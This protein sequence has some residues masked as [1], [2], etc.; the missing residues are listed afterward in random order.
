MANLT[1][2]YRLYV[3]DDGSIVLKM[4][5]INTN[6]DLSKCS[7]SIR[8]IILIM[9]YIIKDESK[10]GIRRK[11]SDGINSVARQEGINSSSVHAKITRKLGLS[12]SDFKNLVEEYFDSNFN[13]LDTILKNACVARTKA[14]DNYAIDQL[15]RSMHQIIGIS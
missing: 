11:V 8:Q 6:M 2:T 9:D 13:Q 7:S 14:A 5:E 10:K 1:A 15:I 4:D 3:Y 12:M